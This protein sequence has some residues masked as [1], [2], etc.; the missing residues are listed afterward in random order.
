MGHLLCLS[1]GL[2]DLLL[3]RLFGLLLLGMSYLSFNFLCDSLLLLFHFLLLFLSLFDLALQ[4]FLLFFY[5]FFSL[6][7]SF[8]CLFL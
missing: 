2:L 6:F 8:L 5:G 4:N 1:L 7:L 3:E